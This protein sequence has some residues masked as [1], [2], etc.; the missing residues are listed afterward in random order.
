MEEPTTPRAVAAAWQPQL[1]GRRA[2]R[3]IAEPIVE[4]V[5]GGVRVA[6]AVDADGAA[7]YAHGVELDLP[8]E[9]ASAIRGALGATVAVIEGHLTA[10]AL[11]SGEGAFPPQPAFERPP[12][13]IPR[14]LRESVKDDPFVRSRDHVRTALAGEASV[15]EALA[16]GER[17]A[18]V[19]TDLLWL[20]GELLDDVPLLERKRLLAAVLD[21]SFLV[22][23][24]VFVRPSA[25]MT[26][27]AWGALGFAE[28]SYQGSNSRYLFG[29]ENPDW[30][31][32]RAPR[33][34]A[35]GPRSSAP[36]R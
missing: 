1:P 5:W 35:G 6:V 3:D 7:A 36:F 22:R 23:V 10:E 13:L 8:D 19:A 32:V 9:L 2:A 15:L 24:T 33:D 16:A 12:I 20:D 17:H 4:P 27:V 18:F 14:G 21:E 11:R 31:V 34:A 29:R 30:A 28:L 25:A 26:L